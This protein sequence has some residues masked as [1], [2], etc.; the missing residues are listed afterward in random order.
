[1]CVAVC[2]EW[3]KAYWLLVYLCASEKG[4][5]YKFLWLTFV[6]EQLL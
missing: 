4:K 6:L 1:M 2:L 3:F 5:E